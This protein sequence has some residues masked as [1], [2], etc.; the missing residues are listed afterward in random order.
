MLPAREAPRAG[1]PLE[2]VCMLFFDKNVE[3]AE[4]AGASET[5]LVGRLLA[6]KI[7]DL[8]ERG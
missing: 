2:I 6:D 3:P 1:Q 8:I 4:R 7:G 5:V